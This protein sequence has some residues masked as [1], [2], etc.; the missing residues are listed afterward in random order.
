M[1]KSLQKDMALS[2]PKEAIDR[3][4]ECPNEFSCLSSGQ[5]GDCDTCKVQSAHSENILFIEQEK[6]QFCPYRL[7]VGE[8]QICRCPVHYAIYRIDGVS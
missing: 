8:D 2:I 6:H 7:S 5:C 3:A 4:T 1:H